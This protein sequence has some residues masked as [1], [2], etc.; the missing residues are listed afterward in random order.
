MRN[1]ANS[2][3]Q[4]RKYEATKK[5][6]IIGM[7]QSCSYGRA[8]K[9]MIMARRISLTGVQVIMTLRSES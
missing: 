1:C 5:V 3:N 9:M 4:W 7:L 6:M 8:M 2:W